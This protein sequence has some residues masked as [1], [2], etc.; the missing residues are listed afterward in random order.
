[1]R[2]GI[3]IKK[4]LFSMVKMYEQSTKSI[5]ILILLFS[6]IILIQGPNFLWVILVLELVS[7][8]FLITPFIKSEPLNKYTNHI[9]NKS[10]NR[11]SN[12]ESLIT[13][14]FPSFFSFMLFLI[15]ALFSL[16]SALGFKCEIS[17]ILI[18]LSIYIKIG[19]VPFCIYIPKVIKGLGFESIIYFTIISKFAI[20]LVIIKYMLL[21]P[22]LVIVNNAVCLITIFI[23]SIAL[24]NSLSINHFIGWSG[25]NSFSW[26]LLSV[27]ISSTSIEY[28][29]GI[30]TSIVL[31]VFFVSYSLCVFNILNH[32][33]T[34]NINISKATILEIS[35]E[36]L[37]RNS[38]RI[39][40]LWITIFGISGFP[41][42]IM[43]GA[44]LLYLINMGESGHWIIIILLL[45]SSLLTSFAYI[46]LVWLWFY[47]SKT[48]SKKIHEQ[49]L[50][51]YPSHH[52]GFI[53]GM[54][55]TI[56]LFSTCVFF[57]I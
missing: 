37:F 6:F 45:V 36:N 52:T 33:R 28:S 31:I 42:F 49:I 47:T 35:S 11:I 26:I 30:S 50:P 12:T 2:V 40:F 17:Q 53:Q 41:P 19:V 13:Y 16:N 38:N 9:Y 56:I 3:L 43:F 57:I 27:G 4:L 18:L 22:N 24:L 1:M 23:S 8:L 51:N 5:C 54:S 7:L 25:I 46:R 21:F 20:L 32:I 55:M 15:A 29:R 44:K 10:T 48:V 34:S 14:L 39:L